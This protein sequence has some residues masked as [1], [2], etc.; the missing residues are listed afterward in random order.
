MDG[1]RYILIERH[2]IYHKAQF[3]RFLRYKPGRGTDLGSLV[4][5]HLSNY[6]LLLQIVQQ[7]L[8][9]FLYVHRDRS[10][11]EPVE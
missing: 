9:L 11:L 5:A 4:G 6:P 3:L 2:E 7:L 1:A 8:G 10:W